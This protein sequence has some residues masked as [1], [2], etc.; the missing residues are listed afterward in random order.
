MSSEKNAEKRPDTPEMSLDQ[1]SDTIKVMLGVVQR[2]KRQ[3]ELQKKLDANE[4]VEYSLTEDLLE[5][6]RALAF[7][8]QVADE[9]TRFISE[10]TDE[11]LDEVIASELA[12]EREQETKHEISSFVIE[13]SRD[14]PDDLAAERVLH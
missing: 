8:Q 1:L 4:P 2:L 11:Q 6:E 10:P 12:Y 9:K 14:D 3:L 7:L 13:I 5:N